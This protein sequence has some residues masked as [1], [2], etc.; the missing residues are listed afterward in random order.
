MSEKK[1]KKW[2]KNV[3]DHMHKGALKAKA[4][5]AGE[6]TGAYAREHEGDSGK[7]G[8]QARLAESLMAMHKAHNKHS[9]SSKNIRHS[10]YGKE[11]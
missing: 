5:K 8:K 9:V 11:D 2:V 4:E 3:T 6:S 1:P 7:T 10:M